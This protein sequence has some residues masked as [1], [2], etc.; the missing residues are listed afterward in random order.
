METLPKPSHITWNKAKVF[1]RPAWPYVVWSP[2]T[3]VIRCPTHP[4]LP[5]LWRD[6]HLPFPPTCQAQSWHCHRMHFLPG[7]LISHDHVAKSLISF[8]ILFQYLLLDEAYSDILFKIATLPLTTL[9]CV[10]L[11]LCLSLD[12]ELLNS[13]LY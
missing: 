10:L 9:L 6:C 7:L 3:S 12:N 2:F 4:R 5:Q 11:C 13:P 1:I 8:L